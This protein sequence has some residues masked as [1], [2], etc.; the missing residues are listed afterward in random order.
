MLVDRHFRSKWMS[1]SFK[2]SWRTHFTSTP[3]PWDG[4]S[5]TSFFLVKRMQVKKS[6]PLGLVESCGRQMVNLLTPTYEH[7]AAVSELKQKT[8]GVLVILS[9]TP[10][11]GV[12]DTAR[13]GCWFRQKVNL[14]TLKWSLLSPVY[15]LGIPAALIKDSWLLFSVLVVMKVFYL[16]HQSFG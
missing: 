10:T 6:D 2:K 8:F 9:S 3:L 16:L 12:W 4:F 15:K 14:L 13:V 11:S 7:P 5:A 1:A